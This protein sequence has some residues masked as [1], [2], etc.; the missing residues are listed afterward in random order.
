MAQRFN[1]TDAEL[2]IG[3]PETPED[4]SLETINELLSK[5]D[6]KKDVKRGDIVQLFPET[7]RN[8]FKFIFD[9]KKLIALDTLYDDYGHLPQEFQFPE[10]SFDHWD[11][12]IEHNKI[13]W[14][15]DEDEIND[16]G[17]GCNSDMDDFDYYSD[18]ETILTD[19]TGAEERFVIYRV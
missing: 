9:G 12:V 2:K 10:F 7:Y 1:I 14:F 19:E 18:W 17:Y 6:F 16:A 11:N 5:E 13:R 3:I 15:A 4:V 8:D